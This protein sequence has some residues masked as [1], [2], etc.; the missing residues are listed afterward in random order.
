MAATATT[1]ASRP[2][3]V[4]RRASACTTAWK[5]PTP[6]STTRSPPPG[7]IGNLS[8]PAPWEP[9]MAGRR[10]RVTVL[11]HY[12]YPDDVVSSRHFSDFCQDL[13]EQ[14]WDVET[15]PCNRACRDESQC[16]PLSEDWQDIAV[17]RVWRPGFRQ[18]SGLGR[19]LNAAWMLAA[20]CLR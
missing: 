8:T 13:H 9:P 20:W 16:Y 12:F 14:G 10:P 17:R 5:R 7:R 3:W 19:I 4:G 2:C 18:A 15:W 6:G 11:Y 1:P